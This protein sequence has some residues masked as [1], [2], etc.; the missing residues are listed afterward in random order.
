MFYVV[1]FHFE[2][3]DMFCAY[4]SE[5]QR[6]GSIDRPG[7]ATLA[8]VGRDLYKSKLRASKSKLNH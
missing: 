8:A 6:K 4:V 3:V 5:K 7:S 1:E 2:A